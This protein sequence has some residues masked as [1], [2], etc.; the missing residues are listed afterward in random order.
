MLRRSEVIKAGAL[1]TK[2][3]PIIAVMVHDTLI[4]RKTV[5]LL[6]PVA[7]H[8]ENLYEANAVDGCQNSTTW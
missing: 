7:L 3:F 6:L 8:G 2:K 1:V 4:L 5:F